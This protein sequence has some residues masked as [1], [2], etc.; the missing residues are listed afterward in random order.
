MTSDELLDL[1]RDEAADQ[2]APYLWSDSLIYSYVDDAQKMFCRLTDG[3]SDATSPLTRLDVAVGDSYLATSPLILRLR[4]ASRADTGRAV[5]VVNIEDLPARGW[6]YD[7]RTGPV[8]ALVIGEEAGKARTYPLPSE[9]LTI[10]LS[11]F[12]LPRSSIAN[13][14]QPLEIDEQHHRHLLMWAK[15]LA[16]GKQDAETFDRNKKQGY[17]A[18]FRGYCAAVK[19]EQQRARFK[20]RAVAYG[21]I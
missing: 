17:E 20:T 8:D 10:N 15:S 5:E 21:G 13:A 1:F 4:N 6:R 16:Y 18:E 14:G 9:A 7:G 19:V 3:I 12:R 2:E 11:V